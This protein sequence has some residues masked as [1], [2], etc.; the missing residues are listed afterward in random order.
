MPRM[1][2]SNEHIESGFSAE[3]EIIGTSIWQQNMPLLERLTIDRESRQ[4][5]LIRLK[6]ALGLDELIYLPTCNRVEFIYLSSGKHS[7]DH[8]LHCIIDYFFKGG[9][10]LNFFPNDFYHYSGKEAVTHLFRTVA[11]L[12]SLVLG[13]SQITSQFKQALQDAQ[14]Y[15]IIG[16]AL[17]HLGCEALAVTRKIKRDTELGDGMI[18]MASLAFTALRESLEGRRNLVIALVGSGEMTVKLARYIDEARLGDLLF[19]NRT[20]SKAESLAAQFGGRA[21]SLDDFKRAPESVDGIMSS[22]A[23]TDPIFDKNFMETLPLAVGPVVCIDLAVPRDFSLDFAG[24]NRIILIDIPFLKTR[25][26]G[27]VKRRFVEAGRA[28]ALVKQ[29]V[30][31][32]LSRRIELS[33][34]PIFKSS[35]DESQRFAHRTVDDLFDCRLADLNDNQKA[36]VRELAGKLVGFSSYRPVKDLSKTLVGGEQKTFQKETGKKS[37]EAG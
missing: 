27:N 12:E 18:S 9:R 31:E 34:R 1:T 22:T 4:E 36:A 20:L 25:G 35:F 24:D 16:P 15:G 19:V 23:S 5:E 2:G 37:R 29:A 7:S 28:N 17:E 14:E 8:L 3:V 26:K 10:D 32:Y 11:S 21:V 6:N 30:A 33:L 13:E